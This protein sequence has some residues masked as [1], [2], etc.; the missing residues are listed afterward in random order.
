[1]LLMGLLTFQV[2]RKRMTAHVGVDNVDEETATAQTPAPGGMAGT[3]T[4]AGGEHPQEAISNEQVNINEG[5]NE[6]GTKGSNAARYDDQRDKGTVDDGSAYDREQGD[7][8]QGQAVDES[9]DARADGDSGSGDGEE[10]TSEGTDENPTPLTLTQEQFD[11][12][13]RNA[14]NVKAELDRRG[15][16][17]DK[18]AKASNVRELLVTALRESGELPNG[19]E[20]V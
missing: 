5:E 15:I 4:E 17:Y 9:G 16:E 7:A 12:I 3:N 18:D 10:S 2:A 6:D 19:F 1:M 11:E 14:T 20:T 13:N 8:G